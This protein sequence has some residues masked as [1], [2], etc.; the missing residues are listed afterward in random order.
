MLK[1]LAPVKLRGHDED[2]FVV[3][4][5]QMAS[6]LIAGGASRIYFVI[7]R[8]KNAIREYFRENDLFVGYLHFKNQSQI[9]TFYGMP[10]A[11]DE[12]Y[13]ESKGRIVMLGM[14]DTLIEPGDSF[15]R[16]LGHFKDH[17]ADL[18]LGLYPAGGRNQGGFITVRKDHRVVRQIDKTNKRFPWNK[19]DNMWGIACWNSRFADFMHTFIRQNRENY[20][21]AGSG[22]SKEMLFGNVIDAAITSDDIT[23]CAA[24]IDTEKGYYVDIGEPER[25]FQAIIRIN[26][27]S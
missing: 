12:I 3:V 5:E 14:P 7:S 26:S 19:A 1:E 22:K 23:V 9:D 6:N 18:E 17:H 27:A 2:R 4:S 8:K 13:Q 25:Y 10:F 16:L 11:I 20:R 15:K 21:Y 24:F